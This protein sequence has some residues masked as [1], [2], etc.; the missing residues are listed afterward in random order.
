MVVHLLRRSF[1]ILFW[2]LILSG[3]H[4]G[5]AQS[6]SF[7]YQG[8]LLDAGNP[9][10]GSYE[11]QFKL[12]D[13]LVAGAQI[14]SPVTATVTVADGGF[15]APLDFGATTF[16]GAARYLE[17]GVRPSGSPN[18]F[19]LLSPRQQILSSPYGIRTLSAANSDNATLLGGLPAG[20]FLQNT[21]TQQTGNFNISGNGTIAG[22]GGSNTNGQSNSIFGALAGFQNTSSFNSF[23]GSSAGGH[24]TTGTNNSFVGSQAGVDNTTGSD[25]VYVGSSAGEFN[26]TGSSNT[27]IG[28]EA[29]RCC[30]TDKGTYIG[31]Q[32]RPNNSG[33]TNT[34]AIGANAQVSQSNSLILGSIN[35]ANGA[36]ADTLVGIGTTAPKAKLDL[37]GGNILIGS[38]GQGIILKS[39]NGATCKLLS[40]D[41]A[42]AMALS[43]V[44][45]P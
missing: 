1:F 17:I 28:L 26:L 37:T 9:A 19:T 24:N 36:I 43:A 15:T 39:P 7:S 35:G 23:F 40:I 20:G 45:C 3:L 21:T 5:L 10:N 44:A 8:R 32:T 13:A 6:T 34:T 38:P 29:G 2:A 4:I 42:G 31:Y 22:A 18:P 30:L 14:G 33:L 41:N 25:N 16:N 12:F 27:F 11:M